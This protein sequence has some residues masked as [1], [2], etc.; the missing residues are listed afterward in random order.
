MMR[1]LISCV[2]VLAVFLLLAAAPPA[3]TW[4]R[5]YGSGLRDMGND[6]LLLEDGGYLIVGETVVLHEEGMRAK[7]TLLRLTAD[8]DIVWERAYGGD[9]SSSGKSL[10]ESDGGYVIGGT[11]QS[12]DGDDADAYLLRVDSE[13]YEV[14]S[15]LFGTPLNE[16]GGQVLAMNDGGYVLIGD[17]EDPNDVV[18]DPSA[19]GYAGRAGRSNTYIV[20]TDA[21]GNEIWSNRY[22]TQDNVVTSSCAVAPNGGIVVLSYILHYPLDDN[23]IVLRGL[24]AS[25]AELWSRSWVD[26]MASGYDLISTSDGGLIISGLQSFPEDPS[27]TKADVL[28][29]KVDETGNEIWSVT[30]GMPD[31][32][33]TAHAVT[34]T[35]DGNYICVGWQSASLYARTDD[36]LLAAFGREGAPLWETVISSDAHNV[37]GCIQQHADGTYVIVS[38]SAT[39]GDPFRIQLLKVDP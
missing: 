6:F 3:E 5:T 22:E 31:W 24:D 9:R 11:I 36:I 19:A 12:D 8:G 10:V 7:L 34:E 20:R 15:R 18:A 35:S 30:F 26:G 4:I 29:I 28:L 39:S 1:Y 2:A 14:W 32:V 21:N 38:S 23:D 16:Y 27:R 17:S 37:H 33:E 13:G 25:G